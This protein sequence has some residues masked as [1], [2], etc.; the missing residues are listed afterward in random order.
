MES[1]KQPV[2][3]CVIYT[4]VPFKNAVERLTARVGENKECP[5]FV[6]CEGQRLGRPR[7]LKFGCERVFVVEASQNLGQ[8]LFCRRSYY[9]DGRWVAVLSGAVKREFRAI[10]DW[11]QHVLRSSCH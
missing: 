8:W 5:S 1:A 3:R 6:T 11:L 4:P 2:R 9:Q 7:G 10:A